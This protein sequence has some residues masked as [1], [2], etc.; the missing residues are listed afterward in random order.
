[1][2]LSSIEAVVIRRLIRGLPV[3]MGIYLTLKLLELYLRCNNFF[4][5]VKS[6]TT[7][8]TAGA[9]ETASPFAGVTSLAPATSVAETIP[10]NAHLAIFTLCALIAVL[11]WSHH[12]LVLQSEKAQKAILENIKKQ[13]SNLEEAR[14]IPDNLIEDYAARTE[15]Q[16]KS[17]QSIAQLEARIEMLEKEPRF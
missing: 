17:T 4:S 9:T 11:T 2:P 10:V 8:T 13:I 12:N 15:I 5:T 16:K 6:P 14:K 1:M 7:S 3:A